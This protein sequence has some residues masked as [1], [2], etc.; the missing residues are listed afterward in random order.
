MKSRFLIALA[1]LALFAATARAQVAPIQ[2]EHD[3][4]VQTMSSDRFTWIDSNGN[5]RVA[6]LAHND[7][8]GPGGTTGGELRE[9][10][11][12]VGG[13]PRVV[14]AS[15]TGAAGF[16]Y[17]V[18]HPTDNELC[19]N[20]PDTS[21]FGHFY[22]GTWTRLFEGRH[23]VIF[24]FQQNYPRF[25][26][27]M[28]P[29][30]ENDIPVTIDWV[31]STGRDNPLWAVT[32]DMNAIPVNTLNDDS[33]APY[34]ELLFDGSATVM[35]H[36]TIAGVGWGDGYKFFSTTNP[37]TFN[38]DWDWS[39]PNTVPYVKLWTTVVDATM[40]TVMTQTIQQQDAG[41]Y[42]DASKWGK[43]SAAGDACAGLYKMPCDFN[44]DY[45]SINYSLSGADATTN[46][47]RLAWGTEFGFLGQSQYTVNGSQFWGGPN[48]NKTA[49]GHPRKSY[50]TYIV[51][52]THTSGPVE[53]QV[54]QVETVQSLT[55]SINNAVGSVVTTGPAG[56]NRP[57]S[58]TYD[59]A[60]YNHVYGALAFNANTNQLDANIAVGSGT[61]KKPLIIISNFTAV[62]YP[63]VKLAGL[64]L[65]A[66]VD[67]FPS[68]RPSVNELWITLNR[69][70]SG[71]MN[72]FEII[73]SGPP[74]A[75]T[76]LSTRAITN[77]RIDLTW[78]AVAGATY[79]VDRES[80]L[81]GGFV[82]IA[83]PT[84]NSF[85]DT[86]LQSTTAYIYRVRAV[87]GASISPNSS[88]RL[89]TTVVYTD[90]ALAPGIIIKAT[91]L[92]ELRSAVNAARALAV[93]GAAGFTDAATAGTIIK[94]L[95][96]TQLRNALDEALPTLGF[97]SGGY[98]N[99]VAFGVV[100]KAVDFQELR[101]RME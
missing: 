78:N 42:F 83:T 4:T 74:P 96:I 85:S 17:V 66:D 65:T 79:Q 40:G 80:S 59:P 26:T 13:Q 29:A 92:A 33:R 20:V 56:A 62:D 46:S 19:T 43:T 32:F 28:G 76:G 101:D 99:A 87:N 86:G 6:V 44:W 9:F 3:V 72:H 55:L 75:P 67:Y 37:V 21:P 36:S 45:Q 68:L 15:S 89:S 22:G 90:N 84:L 48:P 82:Q 41:G 97:A 50:S 1:A 70:L 10:H 88:P 61:L 11:Y 30:A 24:R 23:H 2:K 91:H 12:L 100:V 53:A 31:F 69:D 52:G 8:N 18:S 73:S 47:T 39:T 64:T 27:N 58:V 25:C 51:L 60:G 14:I 38:S 98:T 94:A 71:A 34:G 5:P 63:T 95:H 77:S 16:G 35:A 57:D 54:T 7:Q 49:A 81:A 93:L